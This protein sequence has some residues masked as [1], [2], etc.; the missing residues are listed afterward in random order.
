[1][2]RTVPLALL[3]MGISVGALGCQHP[4]VSAVSLNRH[5][6]DHKFAFLYDPC[7]EPEGIPFY[8]P[9]PLLIISKNFRNI[10]EAKVGLT[11][12]AP[13]PNYYD[14]QA[15]Y[16][17]LNARTNFQGLDGSAGAA[18]GANSSTSTSTTTNTVP[19]DAKTVASVA[20][21][22]TYS[23]TAPQ[24]TPGTVASDGLKPDAFFTY[25]VIFVPD[26][27]QKYGL[28]ITGGAGEIRAA[29]NLVNGWQFTG[30]GPYYMKDSSTTQNILAGGISANLAANGV[31]DV[32]KQVASLKPG[33]AGGPGAAHQ[34]TLPPVSANQL[35]VLSDALRQL[36][37][38]FLTIPAYAEISIYEPYLSPE[39]T[40]EWKLIAEKSFERNVVATEFRPEDVMS[41]LQAGAASTPTAAAGQAP[42]ASMP[43][44]GQG[45]SVPG[46]GPPAAAGTGPRAAPGDS[47][48]SPPELPK[49]PAP[50]NPGPTDLDPLPPAKPPTIV[51]PGAAGLSRPGP[52]GRVAGLP[53]LPPGPAAS[54]IPPL[55][56]PR[57]SLASGGALRLAAIRAATDPAKADDA[58]FQTQAAAAPPGLDPRAVLSGAGRLAGGPTPVLFLSPLTDTGDQGDGVT[59]SRNPAVA[60]QSAP[61][62]VTLQLLRDGQVVNSVPTGPAPPPVIA[63]PDNGF[64]PVPVGTYTYTVVQINAD[65][66]QA[67]LG[68]VGVSVVA[69]E[70]PAA[71]AP[72]T[73]AAVASSDL[74]HRFVSQFGTLTTPSAAVN[75]APVVAPA[76]VPLAAAPPSSGNQVTLNQFF[77]RTKFPGPAAAAPGP[78]HFSLFHRKEKARPVSRTYSVDGLD[79]AA[80]VAAAPAAAQGAPVQ[81]PR[82]A[83]ETGAKT[84]VAAP[85]AVGNA[86][87]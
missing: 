2:S 76:A 85:A 55:Q 40:M 49:P 44:P 53:P 3:L 21:K 73:T 41:L 16:A 33:G 72:A 19:T 61:P 80:V 9:K 17:D 59:S 32:V 22:T 11:D 48:P 20:A 35:Q 67:P 43:A 57:A 56:G 15:K 87:P 66:S 60:V 65:R 12:S 62:G 83:A 31:A 86:V 23:T 24:V 45:P 37:P 81:P 77:G 74:M 25:H 5:Y 42:V 68:Q 50:G 82:F 63:I 71:A 46:G 8:L 34:S 47:A 69:P 52:S 14:D 26:L 18:V 54:R 10:E 78:R 84:P 79:A 70:A 13:I 51:K 30:L 28:K 38:K 75:A 7:K 6:C 1:M 29:M 4:T 64:G 39:G 27:T 36:S 58:V